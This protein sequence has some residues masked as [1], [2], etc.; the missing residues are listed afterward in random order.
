MYINGQ[1]VTTLQGYTTG[2]AAV[3][4]SPAAT[5]ALRTGQNTLAIHC[6][7]TQGGQYI[8]AG[9]SLLIEASE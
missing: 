3:P 6:H 1:L 8:D 9:V 5:K 7:Q 4:L 2:Y